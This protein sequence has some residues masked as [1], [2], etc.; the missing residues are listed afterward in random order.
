MN[1]VLSE[2]VL[3]RLKAKFGNTE[4]WDSFE[5]LARSIEQAVLI[6]IKYRALEV[7]Q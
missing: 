3:Q 1:T 2:E 5:P 6:A 7:K 4:R